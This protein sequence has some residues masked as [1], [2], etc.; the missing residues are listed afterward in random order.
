MNTPL[1]I[2][3]AKEA[4]VDAMSQLLS[5]LFSIE[6]DFTPD[7]EKQS[8]GL[9]LLLDTISSH[10]VVAQK[11]DRVVGMA[12]VQ[13]LVSTAEGGYVGQVEDVVVDAEHRGK[14]VGRAL[15]D[16]LLKWKR[17]NGLS[18]L[19]LAADID[20]SAALEFYVGKGWKQT[21]LVVLRYGDGSIR[22]HI[23]TGKN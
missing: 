10:I 22:D 2:R 15:L 5:Q 11:H 19:Q 8:R 9:K 21:G 18:R 1:I 13:I 23:V 12:S 16:Y 6:T 3:P 4:D 7:D 20:N 14:G 17:D